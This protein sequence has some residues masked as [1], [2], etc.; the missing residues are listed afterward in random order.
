MAAASG[1]DEK[2]LELR[3]EVRKTMQNQ[4]PE[5]VLVGSDHSIS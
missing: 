2:T 1:Q 3:V 4:K 5:L